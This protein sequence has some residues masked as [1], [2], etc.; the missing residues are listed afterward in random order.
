MAV[1]DGDAEDPVF[2]ET[3]PLPQ[4]RWVVST[5]PQIEINLAL[6]DALRRHGFA[7]RIAMSAHS[8]RDAKRLTHAGVD[9]ALMPFDDAADFAANTI[10]GELF[11]KG[12]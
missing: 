11:A 10:A 6:L 9:K 12:A 7:G 2:P 4:A 8:E 5:L 1:R 3:L